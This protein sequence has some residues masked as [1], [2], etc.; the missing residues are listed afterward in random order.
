MVKTV[1]TEPC[2]LAPALEYLARGWSVLPLCPA[3]HVGVGKAHRGCDHPGKRPFFPNREPGKQGDWK[4]FQSRLA[5]EDEVRGWFD[6]NPYLNV[7]MA[8]G[9]VS[10]LVGIDIDDEEG[11]DLLREFSGGNDPQTWEYSTGKGKRLLYRLAPGVAVSTAP[12]RRPGT[13]IEI[14]RLMGAGSQIVLPPSIHPNGARYRWVPGKS[15][16][17]IPLADVPEWW[18]TRKAEDKQ[19][20]VPHD[21]ELIDEGG[22]DNYLTSLAGSM[23][24]RGAHEEVIYVA[25]DKMNADRCNPPLPESQIRKIARS[26]SR[27]APDE[28]T[29][30]TIKEPGRAP[31]P[32]VIAPGDR[33]FKWASELAFQ[34]TADEWIWNG[35]LPRAGIVLLS[36]LWK[37]G[38]TTLLSHLLKSLADDGKFLGRDIK[39]SRVL[40]V[41][42]EGE[43][44]WVRRRDGLGIGDHAGFYLQPFKAKPATTD[45]IAFVDQLVSDV[46]EH[47]FDLVV[48]DTLAKLWPVR[49]EN[50][51]GAVDD[52]LMPLT[53][54]TKT[55]A[56]VLL[57]HHLRKSGG[58]EYTGSRGSGALSAFPDIV[59]ELTRFDATDP[60]SRKRALRAKGRYDETPDEL[61]IELIDGQYHAVEQPE[62]GSGTTLKVVGD[63]EEAKVLNALADT[64]DAWVTIEYLREF[65]RARGVGMRN[66]DLSTHLFSLYE[67]KQV[68]ICGVVR[69]KSDPRKY[70]LA[71]RSTPELQV[72]NEISEREEFEA[73]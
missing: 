31:L 19:A 26:V 69:S 33:R 37:V 18:Q 36:A 40:Y 29:A 2:A 71:S 12:F 3:F 21:G 30:V 72:G 14:L 16:D 34:H 49:E 25:L 43:Q 15:P 47:K 44:H 10:Q 46:R 6:A 32:A 23:R 42:E 52:A 51:A 41:S 60:K 39:A 45:W 55:G 66:A 59:M 57:I 54:I 20:S 68:V 27:Y 38:K 24:K 9:P 56:G 61:V 50:D 5:T 65:L 1:E 73:E 53:G 4:E 70:S 28:Y 17:D 63:S 11:E 8:L 35:Y 58:A 7:G 22:R 64:P 62:P 48:F 13:E 67:R